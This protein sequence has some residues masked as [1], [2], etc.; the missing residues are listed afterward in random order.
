[1]KK[2]KR[3]I[4]GTVLNLVTSRTWAATH[5]QYI[6]TALSHTNWLILITGSLDIITLS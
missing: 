5:G 2:M 3:F 1:M 6:L 4:H